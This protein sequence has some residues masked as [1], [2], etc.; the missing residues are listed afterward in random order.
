MR[1]CFFIII[2]FLLF[3]CG[4]NNNILPSSTGNKSDVL[5]VA[6]ELF[7]NNNKSKIKQIFEQPMSGISTVEPYFKII[8][9]NHFEF[10]NIFKRNKNILIFEDNI[11]SSIH[12]NKW[13]KNQLAVFLKANQTLNSES[14]NK[15]LKIFE[16]N[17]IDLIKN[18][19]RKKSNKLIEQDINN[20]FSVKT[21]LPNIYTVI[22][23]KEDFFWATYNPPNIE[24]IQHIMFFVIHSKSPSDTKC[25]NYTD[26][27]ISNN[28]FGNKDNTYVKL[29]ELYQPICDNN[30]CRGLWKLENGFM[31]GPFLLKKY[32][33][34]EKTIISVGLVF[35]PQKNKR[36]YMKNLEAI[37]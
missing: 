15:T 1:T 25:L 13:A 29:E 33:R 10:K 12:K 7:W 27:V 17:E 23:N 34:D 22:E 21:F 11:K 14:L 18:E 28:I 8:H 4:N 31:G 35:A 16:A 36:D 32:Y 2:T 30:I 20:N 24:E 6:S 37:L 5:V 26:S 9:I 19:I 3:S